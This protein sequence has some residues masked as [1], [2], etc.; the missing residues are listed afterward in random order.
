MSDVK[1]NRRRQRREWV[2]HHLLITDEQSERLNAR[3]EREAVSVNHL[4]RD[5]IEA[6]YPASEQWE[7]EEREQP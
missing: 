1:P 7:V 6:C 2:E 5:A 3:A 4:I